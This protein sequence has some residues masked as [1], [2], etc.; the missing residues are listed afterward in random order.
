MKIKLYLN[1]NLSPELAKRLGANDYD[2]I[3]SHEAA[4][5]SENDES[6]MQY[7]VLESRAIVTI[8]KKD[9][10][11]IH[12]D[13]ITKGIEHFG[14]ILSTDED[15]WIIY[16]RLLKLLTTLTAEEINNQLIWLNNFR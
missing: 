1:E 4:M 15:H 2:V 8:N 10:I 12:S 3:S 16:R 7:A 11:A 6:Q 13:Y 5:D 9:F 14:I